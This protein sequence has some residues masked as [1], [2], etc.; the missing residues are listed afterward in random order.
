VWRPSNGAWYALLSSSG[1]FYSQ[2]FG[3]ST[4][5]PAPGDFDGDG[6]SDVA[7]LRDGNW[8]INFS[9]NGS[10]HSIPFGAAGDLPVQS[11]FVGR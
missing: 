2:A 3:I 8:Y 4:D 7:V 9:S 6:K 11:G 10:F 5:L 1:A